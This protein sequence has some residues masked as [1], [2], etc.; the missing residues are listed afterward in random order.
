MVALVGT[1]ERPS[2]AAALQLQAVQWTGEEGELQDKEELE[3]KQEE[4]EYEEE[5][6][7]RRRRSRGG[8]GDLA[9]GGAGRVVPPQY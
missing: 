8:E 4:E 9:G 1:R 2:L 7:G 6:R 5:G 3:K